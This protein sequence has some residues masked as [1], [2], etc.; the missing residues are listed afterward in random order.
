MLLGERDVLSSAQRQSAR[1]KKSKDTGVVCSKQ[2]SAEH[3]L[4]TG[5]TLEPKGLVLLLGVQ[6]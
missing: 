1:G 4:S 5:T 6:V 3:Q 2:I